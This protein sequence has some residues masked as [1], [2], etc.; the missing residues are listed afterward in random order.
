V[1]QT[2]T[3]AALAKRREKFFCSVTN[4]STLAMFQER[5]I[6]HRRYDK[7]PLQHGTFA[8]LISL[9]MKQ[10]CMTNSFF[11]VDSDPKTI[12]PTI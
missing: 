1:L 3:G 9:C 4:E 10:K 6:A 5:D 12:N 8:M 11:F 7:K 2:G